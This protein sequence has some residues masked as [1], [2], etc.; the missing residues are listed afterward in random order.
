MSKTSSMSRE[1]ICEELVEIAQRF[2]R[3]NWL[4]ATSGNLSI[5]CSEK[6]EPLVFGVTAS[7]KD[8]ERLTVHDIVFVDGAC[9]PVETTELRPS[10][11]TMIHAKIYEAT[12]CGSVLHVHTVP[13][14][15]LSELFFEQGHVFLKDLELIKG[16]DIW[17]EGAGIQVPII[18][19][20]ADI[21]KLANAI[22][23]RLDPRI[24][25]VLIRKHG[26]CAWGKNPFEAR[27]HVEAFEFMFSYYVTYL[28]CKSEFA[29]ASL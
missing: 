19:N 20:Y 22:Q 15:V 3:K 8:K 29:N 13:N 26:I 28:S 17:E 18:E 27:R 12:G 16:L 2:T 5:R 4:P 1:Y 9:Q 21:P 24:P 25:G 10:A 6:D 14:N 7:G 23:E 11:E